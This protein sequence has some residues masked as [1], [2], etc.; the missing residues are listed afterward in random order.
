VDQRPDWLEPRNDDVPLV[1]NA[2]DVDVITDP[3]DWY[4]RLRI[5]APLAFSYDIDA[6]IVTRYDDV[7]AVISESQRFS[8]VVLSDSLV[9]N[10][11]NS[12]DDDHRRYRRAV[13]RHFNQPFMIS[14]EEEIRHHAVDL[15]RAVAAKPE[16]DLVRD[17][18]YVLP[19]G[20]ISQLLGVSDED[21]ADIADW[22]DAIVEA[23]SSGLGYDSDQRT[24][25]MAQLSEM[26]L[27]FGA[28]I[29][30]RRKHPKDDLVSALV[31]HES[32]AVDPYEML[33]LVVTLM[34]TGHVTTV[35]MLGF[36]LYLGLVRPEAWQRARHE[37]WPGYVEETLRY[38]APLQLTIRRTRHPVTLHGHL[39]PPET[40]IYACM[41]AANRDPDVFDHPD[42]FRIDRRPNRHLA[43]GGGPHLCLA[44]VLARME[45]A[46][47]FEAM[48]DVLPTFSL[49]EGGHK[50]RE[51]PGA[52][53]L[54]RLEVRR[55]GRSPTSPAIGERAPS[56]LGLTQAAR[57]ARAL[58][59]FGRDALALRTRSG[60]ARRLAVPAGNN[61]ANELARL[62][63][64]MLKVGQFL[65]FVDV[66]GFDSYQEALEA[67][68]ERA[69]P[70][71][72]REVEAILDRELGGVTG[73]FSSIDP[74]PV[75]AASIGQV[76]RAR[77][78]AGQDV[79]VKVQYPDSEQAVL[80]DLHKTGLFSR[81]LWT[82]GRML[83]FETTVQA[84]EPVAEELRDRITEELDYRR[85]AHNQERFRKIHAAD[86]QIRVPAVL[87]HLSTSEVL[88]SSWVDGH[89]W[90]AARQA[91]QDRR[92][93]WGHAIF[94]FVFG[95]L[96]RYSLFNADPHPGN[97]V[98]HDD[99]TVTFLDFGCVKEFRTDDTLR[100]R[101]LTYAS[102]QGD[103]DG[104]SAALD[105]L[106][107]LASGTRQ[108]GP[109]M[110][111]WLDLVYRPLMTDDEFTFT[112]EYAREVVG[113]YASMTRLASDDHERI[114]LPKTIVMLSRINMG[115]HS[116]LGALGA[117]G[118]WRRTFDELVGAASQPASS[119]TAGLA[120]P[121][122]G[123]A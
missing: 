83:G 67:V 26:G 45:G 80:A 123:R 6:Y 117:T 36:G 23:V 5:E 102:L 61:L 69:E 74:E 60:S 31:Q 12:D 79:A 28:L 47:A 35:N 103:H 68:R 81:F 44:A 73:A 96:Y 104:I 91:P 82:V 22:A 46:L 65:S 113:E 105:G 7:R 112:S 48:A 18:A 95:T 37:G 40:L 13:M 14:L 66:P 71:P 90:D 77:T 101:S 72:F 100:L 75:A 122:A 106:G 76:H 116:V 17:F 70:I 62:R 54:E 11:F 51:R 25:A 38:E 84:L 27:Y 64:V 63:G 89:D 15:A 43:F 53:G 59:A 120:T 121:T 42:D 118:R 32:D 24:L 4:R 16:V 114:L 107:V 2:M 85:E 33:L 19:I 86:E 21:G 110:R 94:R 115:I 78:T 1:L 8:N 98:F 58:T 52:H 55:N 111:H 109:R 56:R 88:T 20:I 50:V 93:A 57:G 30:S 97:Y 49:V 87:P 10:I 34:L 39:I 92:D 108:A 3:Y 9:P 99:G 29:E 41:G 119:P